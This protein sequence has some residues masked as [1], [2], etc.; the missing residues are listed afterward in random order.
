[1]YGDLDMIVHNLGEE[2]ITIIPVADVHLGAA[3]HMEKEWADFCSKVLDTPNVYLTIGGDLLNNSV[4]N[5]IGDIYAEKYNPSTQK[6]MMVD[7]LKPL[8]SRILAGCSGNHEFRSKREVDYNPSFEIFCKL[9]IEHLWRENVAFM[10]IQLG[11]REDINGRRMCQRYRPTY[12]VCLTHG[13]GG[14]S[15]GTAVLRSE[16]FGLAIDNLDLLIVG[17]T[18]KPFVT[19]PAKIV[20]DPRNDIVT[21]RPFQIISSSSWMEWGGYAARKMLLPAGHMRQSIIL[22]AYYKEMEVRLK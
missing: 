19:Q 12:T 7:F 3:E 14:G 6:A 5:S 15:T 17:H 20:I 13:S 11:K 1:M 16:R 18:H 21:I 8:S 10:K 2:D 22:S 4:K 9:N